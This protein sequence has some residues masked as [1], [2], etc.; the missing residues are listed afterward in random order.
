MFGD[1][2]LVAPKLK[3]GEPTLK[4]YLVIQIE[5]PVKYPIDVY[6]PEG[7]RWFFYYN[8]MVQPSG[9]KT[10]KLSDDHQGI[11][12]KGGK[13]IPIKMHDGEL[14]LLRAFKMPI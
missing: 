12:V 8:K 9:H 7:E 10:I 13:I 1:S 5:G 4:D 2:I 11:F 14:S 6:L 3:S